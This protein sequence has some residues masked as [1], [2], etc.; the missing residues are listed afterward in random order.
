MTKDIKQFLPATLELVFLAGFIM[1]AIGLPLGVLAASHCGRWPD[2]LVRVI[3]L[4]TVSAPGFVWAVILML[5]FAFYLPM[6]P[7]AGRISDIFNIERTTGFLT[8]DTL[9]AG[10]FAAFRS[11]VHHLI[12]PQL[13]CPCLVLDRPHV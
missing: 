2:H 11:A 9:L 4:L 10:N 7:I 1:I 13:P 8:I 3:A 5:V 12:L 6:F